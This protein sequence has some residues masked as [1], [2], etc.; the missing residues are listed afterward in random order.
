[1]KYQTTGKQVRKM[2]VDILKNTLEGPG[3]L[4]PYIQFETGNYMVRII[5]GGDYIEDKAKNAIK[6]ELI[7]PQIKPR[8]TLINLK[9]MDGQAGLDMSSYVKLICTRDDAD[10]LHREL[11]NCLDSVEDLNSMYREYFG[12][13]MGS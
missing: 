5:Y 13:Y 9:L 6:S 10:Q 12:Q 7:V 8:R 1:M 3:C 2:A 4:L 11:L